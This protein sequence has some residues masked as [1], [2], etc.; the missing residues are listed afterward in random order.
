MIRVLLSAPL[1]LHI[2]LSSHFSCW[3]EMWI[4]PRRTCQKPASVWT[5]LRGAAAP[6]E[7][8]AANAG[9]LANSAVEPS[10]MCLRDINIADSSLNQP[11]SE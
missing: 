9:M 8:S 3:P 6:L 10:K 5:H 2:R 11:R 7:V 4:V 1:C